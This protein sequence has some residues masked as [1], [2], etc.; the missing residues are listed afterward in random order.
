[1]DNNSRNGN[2]GNQVQECNTVITY[3][4]TLPGEIA[5]LNQIK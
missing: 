1:M 4:P 5:K 3:H 2:A